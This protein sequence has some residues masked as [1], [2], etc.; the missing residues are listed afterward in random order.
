MRRK[1]G[2]A[3]LAALVASPLTADAQAPAGGAASGAAAG[4]AA[5]GPI[6]AAPG[7]AGDL[8]SADLAPRFRDFVLNEH[9]SAI[10]FDERL[11]PG[12][13]LPLSGVTYYPVPAEYGVDRR[14]RYTVVNDH[15]VLVDSATRR[16]VQVI[17]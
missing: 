7:A 10:R 15:V 13:R 12:A 2:I 5:G 16:I 17:D 1:F 14:Y 6:S 3:V 9:R 8:L 4:H 11:A